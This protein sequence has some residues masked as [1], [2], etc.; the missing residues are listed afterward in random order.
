LAVVKR[1]VSLEDELTVEGHSAALDRADAEV[2]LPEG[3]AG[4]VGP[5]V[6]SA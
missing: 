4:R 1:G 2:T 6:T 5:A 3:F